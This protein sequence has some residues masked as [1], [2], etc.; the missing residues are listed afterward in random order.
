MSGKSV[1]SDVSWT[2]VGLSDGEESDTG[3][4][5]VKL[6][7]HLSDSASESSSDADSLQGG[8]ECDDDIETS[9]DI[10]LSAAE[11]LHREVVED[12]ISSPKVV[13]VN[14]WNQRRPMSP[15]FL[16]YSAMSAL[17]KAATCTSSEEESCSDDSDDES[18]DEQQPELRLEHEREQEQGQEQGQSQCT[19]QQRFNNVSERRFTRSCTGIYNTISQE[20]MK[21]RVPSELTSH[22]TLV[23][24]T[25]HYA[26]AMNGQ[27]YPLRSWGA[28][29][30]AMAAVLL[31]SPLCD[32]SPNRGFGLVMPTVEMFHELGRLPARQLYNNDVE[33]NFPRV[34]GENTLCTVPNRG[35]LLYGASGRWV[36][37]KVESVPGS[38]KYIFR[39]SN[40][41][42]Q[43]NPQPNKTKACY[44]SVNTNLASLEREFAALS[45]ETPKTRGP[46]NIQSTTTTAM[47][48][49]SSPH[50]Q[51]SLNTTPVF[52]QDETLL[53]HTIEAAAATG[54][55]FGGSQLK[56]FNQKAATHGELEWVECRGSNA[57]QVSVQLKDN[58]ATA[59]GL[60][61]KDEPQLL[62]MPV[63]SRE[64]GVVRQ[65]PFTLQPLLVSHDDAVP[66]PAPRPEASSGLVWGG[67][68]TSQVP[69][70][71]EE[72]LVLCSKFGFGPSADDQWR[73]QH[74][75]DLYASIGVF[76]ADKL[77]PAALRRAVSSAPSKWCSMLRGKMGKPCR[78]TAELLA[79]EI[80]RQRYSMCLAAER[81]AIAKRR[82]DAKITIIPA[83]EAQAEG[84]VDSWTSPLAAVKSTSQLDSPPVRLHAAT[85]DKA[86]SSSATAAAASAVTM[87][88]RPAL[89][90]DYG[91]EPQNSLLHVWRTKHQA[92]AREATDGY[93]SSG[94]LKSKEL[95]PFLVPLAPPQ[96]QGWHGS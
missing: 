16:D 68:G 36:A 4:D 33:F 77:R 3:E 26:S 41:F 34:C 12:E 87:L 76:Q 70:E 86:A 80:N 28:A 18:L 92:A 31:V 20:G 45:N 43:A 65:S 72:R 24:P 25:G 58:L 29:L 30:A 62:L 39:C 50:F 54:V 61:H 51:G 13:E 42:F 35:I 78:K 22:P 10:P 75:L 14:D 93:D 52:V 57:S 27:K 64:L 17:S 44:Y 32:R 95:L 73:Q 55:T 37:K 74:A 5:F 59:T 21:L 40:G 79:A 19:P 66:Y 81:E 69:A 47:V 23:R 15:M 1:A 82:K 89:V 85:I 7:G 63:S 11:E 8:E 84:S 90:L 53:D 71:K 94:A 91:A 88:P 9:S 67:L 38:N 96:P 46:M 2:V 56:T 48:T 83:E 49:S 60:L 6:S